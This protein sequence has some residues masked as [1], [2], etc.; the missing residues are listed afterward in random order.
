LA[1]FLGARF[2]TASLGEYAASGGELCLSLLGL[3]PQIGFIKCGEGL[4]GFDDRADLDQTFRY[5]PGHPEA[6]IA[7]DPGANDPDEAAVRNLGL[8]MGASDQD[9]PYGRYVLRR[10]LVAAGQCQR[11]GAKG[12]CANA[13]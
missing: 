13:M 2:G 7:F 4:A 9:R 10:N 12:E 11:R 8:V 3:Q 1:Q 5:L 6:Q